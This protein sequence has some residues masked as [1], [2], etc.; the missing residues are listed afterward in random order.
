MSKTDVCYLVSHGFSARMVFQTG[1][2]AKVGASGKKTA[3]IAPDSQ[4]TNLIRFC[5]D[6]E[7]SLSEFRPPRNIFTVDY[8]FKRKYFLEDIRNNPGLWAK[9]LHSVKGPKSRNPY[10]WFAPYY[11]FLLYKLI[12]WFPGIRKRFIEAENRLLDSPEAVE[13]IRKIDPKLVVATYPVN[14]EEAMLLRA[15][16]KLKI[17]TAIHLLSWDNITCKGHFPATADYYIAWGPI[18]KEEFQEYYQVEEDR[19]FVCGVPHFDA[20]YGVGQNPEVASHLE[21]LKLDPKKPYLFVA[22]SS[23]YFCP[24][25]IDIVEWLAEK[26]S[27]GH[28]GPDM[29]LIVRPHPQNVQGGMADFSWLPRLE[30]IKGPRVSVDYPSLVESNLPW[31]MQEHDMLR[32]SNLLAGCSVCINFGSTVSIDALMVGRPVIVSAFDGHDY[33]PWFK[34]GRRQMDYVHYAKLIETGGI[35][36]SWNFDEFDQQI[37]RYIDQP[38]ADLELR[39]FAIERECGGND[40]RATERVAQSLNKILEREAS[41]N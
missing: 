36:V 21:K 15:A 10:Y 23:P 37:Q 22:M 27:S 12:R 40:G 4:D 30:G 14:L 25:G 33:L 32:L 11:Y 29:Q 2:L 13:T 28:Y 38:D 9:H 34:S 19:I 6:Q 8:L 16:Q 18:M 35:Q 7:V 41:K 31:S 5:E 3:V 17:P 26:V 39:N 24:K 20:H 1:L